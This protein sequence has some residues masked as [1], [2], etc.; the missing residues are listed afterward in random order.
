MKP[1]MRFFLILCII[2]SFSSVIHAQDE[3]PDGTEISLLQWHHVVPRYDEWFDGYTQAWS[4]ANKVDVSIDRIHFDDLPA[5]FAAEIEAGEGHTLVELLF[6]P[7]SLIESLH[8]LSGVNRQALDM[9]GE[10]AATCQATSYLPAS[11]SHYAFT[12]GYVPGPGYYDIARWT[13]AGYPEGPKTYD[14]LL[15]GG[16][17]VFE[18]SGIPVGMGLSPEINS[19]M[20]HRGVIWSFGGR[21]QDE[22]ENVVLNSEATVAAVDYL[23]RLQSEAM[24]DEVFDWTA[25]SNNQ[26]LVAGEVS[27]I[28]NSI[29]AYRRL[30]KIDAAAA[31]NIGFTSALEGPSGAFGPAH[32]WQIY[33]IPSYVE[34]D[35]L[36]AAKR[37]ILDHSASYSDAVY[38]SE[39]YN[40]PCYPGMV[41]ELDSWLEDDPFDSLPA[42]KLEVLKQVRDWSVYP[43]YPGV[44]SPAISQVFDERII[45]RM[46]AQAARGE[47]SAED[48]VA[49]AAERIE[50]IFAE[51]REKGL[52]G[53]D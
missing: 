3:F 11:D 32:V 33:V 25:S 43:G 48:A 22:N 45:S 27:Y 35:E 31:E 37:F 17:A 53:G 10:R 51:W 36:A 8:D 18:A 38:H 23:A 5:A 52:V 46:S 1:A 26:A 4:Q 19:E 41:E 9:F 14:D 50:E 34:G 2:A 39:L 20:A 30:Q 12:H 21:I 15:T 16:R 13:A 40:F 47:M 49:Q 29:S 6:P 24:T 28:Q 42:D 44:N 7:T